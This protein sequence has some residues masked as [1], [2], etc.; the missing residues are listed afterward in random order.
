MKLKWKLKWKLKRTFAYG[1]PAS[2]AIVQPACWLNFL[3]VAQ[4]RL[5]LSE[6]KN[7]HFNSIL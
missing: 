5:R 3:R 1:L 4:N 7:F 6:A 2:K